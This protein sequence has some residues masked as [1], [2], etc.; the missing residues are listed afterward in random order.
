MEKKRL[1]RQKIF[2]L[3]VMIYF[4]ISPV[5]D[6][7]YFYN[8]YTT[9]FRVCC[10]LLFVLITIIMHKDSRKTFLFLLAYY[11]SLGGYL[12][13]AY[14]HSKGFYSLV[15]DINFSLLNESMTLLKLAMPFTILFI[16]KYQDFDKKD[17]FKVINSWIILI[18]GSIVLLNF[19]G[20]SLSSYT[21]EFT[22]YSI[23]SWRRGLD[24]RLTATKGLFAYTNQEVAILLL[25]LVLSIYEFIYNKRKNIILVI[26]VSLSLIMLGSRIST[27]G[28]LAV[29]MFV[30]ILYV[31]YSLFCKKKIDKSIALIVPIIIFWVA[32]L[33]ISPNNFRVQE[34]ENAT[35]VKESNMAEKVSEDDIQLEQ[36]QRLDFID[37][38][39]NKNL[40]GEQFYR[41]FYPCQYDTEFWLSIIE[42]QKTE[43]LDYRKVEIMIVA[44]VWEVDNRNSNLLLGISNSRI[45][46]MMNIERDFVLQFFAFGI[47]GVFITL[48]FYIFEFV[49]ITISTF[50]N[51]NF[52]NLT[53]A[54]CFCLFIISAFMSGNILN[55]LAT[56]IPSAF[57]VSFVGRYKDC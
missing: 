6:I 29:L 17:F 50:K 33:P 10:L 12:L 42:K 43:R 16:L 11:M 15:P 36:Q 22:N 32:I 34:I 2:K 47:I 45:Q 21:G 55:F 9:L 52:I 39:I 19:C 31:V 49:N 13:L 1:D 44:R 8:H 20:W 54:L 48:F 51:F 41:E 53:I 7:V 56:I 40:I 25:L 46:S 4:I 5:F 38:N 26:I 24:M 37:N 27:Y 28:G 57:V 3:I 30:P 23:F 18:A 14:F 35:R